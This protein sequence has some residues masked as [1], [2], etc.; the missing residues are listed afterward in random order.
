MLAQGL[1]ETYPGQEA[2]WVVELQPGNLSV[3]PG[4]LFQDGGQPA[5]QVEWL[6]C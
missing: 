2:S 1:P 5:V 4:A 6:D 3:G